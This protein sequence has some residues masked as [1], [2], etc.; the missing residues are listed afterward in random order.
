ME[1]KPKIKHKKRGLVSFA[2]NGNNQHGSQVNL[3]C[4]NAIILEVILC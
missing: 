2:N 4:F 3:P 1:M